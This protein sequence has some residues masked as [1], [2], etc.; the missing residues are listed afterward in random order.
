MA[1]RAKLGTARC[2]KIGLSHEYNFLKFIHNFISYRSWE[3]FEI[4]D[5]GVDFV[6]GLH[7]LI[8]DFDTGPNR[9]KVVG[10]FVNHF[11]DPD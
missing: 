4:Q 11:V 2:A 6:E 7:D 9:S 10:K 1:F 8:I 5:S 3:R